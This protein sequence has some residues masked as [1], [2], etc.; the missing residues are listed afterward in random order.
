MS[1]ASVRRLGAAASLLLLASCA[2]SSAPNVAALRQRRTE[3]LNS[4]SSDWSNKS[5]N[6]MVDKYGA[7]D[8]LETLGLVWYNRGPWKKIVVWDEPE[9]AGFGRATRNVEQTIAYPVPADKRGALASFNLGLRVSENGAE[10]SARSESEE[11]NFLLL[12]LADE[13]VRGRLNPEDARASYLRALKLA[14][15]GKT[16]PSMQRLLFQ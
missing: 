14:D 5:S 15:S 3:A 9:F 11:R 13:I 4:G 10:L 1:S 2:P 12:N 16:S 8:R 7:P 6:W